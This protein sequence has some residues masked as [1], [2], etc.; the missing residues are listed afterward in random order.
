M[1]ILLI[2]SIYAIVVIGNLIKL[3]QNPPLSRLKIACDAYLIIV[4]LLHSP[5]VYLQLKSQIG[6]LIRKD[7]STG[8]ADV[9]IKNE[10]ET[11]THYD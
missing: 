9:T 6:K 7:N 3:S 5:I 4:I 10:G 2:H 8:Q 1:I 11:G